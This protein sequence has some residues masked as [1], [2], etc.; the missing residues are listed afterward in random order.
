[1]SGS[2]RLHGLEP[3]RLLRPWNFPG[4][5]PGVGCHFLLQGIFPTQGSNLGLLH[6][7]QTLYRL[8]HQGSPMWLASGPH[9]SASAQSRHG[10]GLS[11]CI[12][13][14][15]MTPNSYAYD[16]Y[17]VPLSPGVLSCLLHRSSHWGRTAGQET[18]RRVGFSSR[19]FAVCPRECGQGPLDC[20]PPLNKPSTG[21]FK[22]FARGLGLGLW[23]LL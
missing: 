12:L 15:L 19:C 8:S 13:S 5:S 22:S 6:C 21:P 4:K 17:P 18:S 14:G 9:S 16:S 11:E 3:T 7:R 2:L 10:Q 23:A 20:W 1:M